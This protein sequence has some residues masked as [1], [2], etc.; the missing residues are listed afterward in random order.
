MLPENLA[1]KRRGRGSPADQ[2]Q[3]LD[4]VERRREVARTTILT[5]PMLIL[6]LASCRPGPSS[7]ES[8]TI[9]GEID[10]GGGALIQHPSGLTVIVPSGAVWDEGTTLT[11]NAAP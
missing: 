4:D 9:V 6:S 11:V 3:P 5:M 2:S 7:P 1:A 10:R 8:Q